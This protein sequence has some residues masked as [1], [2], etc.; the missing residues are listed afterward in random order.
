[1]QAQ[2]V[3]PQWPTAPYL[4]AAA[5]FSLGMNTDAKESLNDCT[6]LQYKRNRNLN[7]V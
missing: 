2:V 6:N 5:L 4:Q 7:F 1:M 3:S